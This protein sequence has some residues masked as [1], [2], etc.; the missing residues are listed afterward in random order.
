MKEKDLQGGFIA[1][2]SAIFRLK[3]SLMF[4]NQQ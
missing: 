2:R 1:E 4:L 3:V